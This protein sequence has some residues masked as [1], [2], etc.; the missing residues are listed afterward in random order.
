IRGRRSASGAIATGLGF[1]LIAILV[2]SFSDFGQHIPANA[3]LTAVSCALVVGAARLRGRELGLESAPP[4]FHGSRLLRIAAL[5][6]MA[7]IA[8]LWFSQAARPRAAEVAF[9]RARE[10]ED[11]LGPAE[12][13]GDDAQFYDLIALAKEAADAEPR[14]VTYRFWLNLYR[15][16]FIASR[17]RDPQTGKIVLDAHKIGYARQL[18]D[19]LNECRALC[20]TFGPAWCELGQIEKF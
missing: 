12:W 1:G 6:A 3:I 13:R 14:N 11:R 15:W 18:V 10:Y 7:A 17:S 2:H 4:E 19:E 16:N 9:A 8:G 5:V 20:P